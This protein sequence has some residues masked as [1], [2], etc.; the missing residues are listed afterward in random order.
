MYRCSKN[1]RVEGG[2]MKDEL[3]RILF[4]LCVIFGVIFIIK[5]Y[6]KQDIPEDVNYLIVGYITFSSTH[7]LEGVDTS[8]YEVGDILTLGDEIGEIIVVD[9]I[10]IQEVK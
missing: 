4:I 10:M 5:S 3:K 7:S 2:V 1:V 9:K 8:G 6:K